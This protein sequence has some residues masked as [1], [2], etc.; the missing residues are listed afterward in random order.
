[1]EKKKEKACNMACPI[2]PR[3]DGSTG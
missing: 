3:I 1:V 2:S